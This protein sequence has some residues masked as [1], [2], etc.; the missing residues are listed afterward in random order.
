VFTTPEVVC[1]Q[2]VKFFSIWLLA[3]HLYRTE[4]TWNTTYT[5][6]VIISWANTLNWHLTKTRQKPHRLRSEFIIFYKMQVV[7]SQWEFRLMFRN[8]ARLATLSNL[9][10]NV[11]C[12]CKVQSLGSRTSRSYFPCCLPSYRQGITGNDG[13]QE[14]KLPRSL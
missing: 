8:N 1:S 13:K 3:R 10:R 6:R 2:G 9:T 5:V 7:L 12:S 11:L 4:N 14:I